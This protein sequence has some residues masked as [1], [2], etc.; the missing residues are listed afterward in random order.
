[1]YI[2]P[3]RRDKRLSLRVYDYNSDDTFQRSL[4]QNTRCSTLRITE[5]VK[6]MKADLNTIHSR[7]ILILEIPGYFDWENN[8]NI[9]IQLTVRSKSGK[10]RH[11]HSIF[12]TSRVRSLNRPSPIHLRQESSKFTI[13][14]SN[15]KI[16]SLQVWSIKYSFADFLVENFDGLY[17][18]CCA[19]RP[20]SW[21]WS[22]QVTYVYLF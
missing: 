18:K 2:F 20:Q 16:C 10:Y 21:H 5:A 12:S 11:N 9:T 4:F 19:G 13:L 7:L 6:K 17:P 22:L 8:H 14:E 3:L 15:N 1:M